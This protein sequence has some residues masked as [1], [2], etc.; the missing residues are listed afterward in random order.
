LVDRYSR[1]TIGLAK[2]PNEARTKIDVETIQ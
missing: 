1:S 2:F